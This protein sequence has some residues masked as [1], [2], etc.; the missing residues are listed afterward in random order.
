M[1]CPP[2]HG[3]VSDQPPPRRLVRHD[4]V[5]SGGRALYVYGA[6]RGEPRDPSEGPE[7]GDDRALHRRLDRL[8][9][10]WVAVSPSR[11]VRP[12]S[13][14]DVVCPLCPGGAELAFGYEAAVF[15]NR[16]PSLVA[17]PPP[18]GPDPRRA[19]SVGR[20]EVVLYTEHHEG[21]LA[22]L[23]PEELANVIGIWRDRTA[24]LWADRRH[25]VVMPFENR[26]EAVGAT[27]SHPHGQLYAFDHLPPV[28]AD[29]VEAA[30][31]HAAG[32]DCLGCAVVRDDEDLGRDVLD[33]PP[34]VTLDVIRF[35]RVRPA[36][37]SKYG[38]I[39]TVRNG[40]RWFTVVRS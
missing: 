8:S 33:R 4:L 2:Y 15:E 12:H 24:A 19:P 34:L 1:A 22:T 10:T 29:R 11:N 25:R 3:P 17:S 23:S 38:W 40:E 21:S 37:A 35:V 27:L 36:H 14:V 6:L 9:G 5:T 20:C 28:I 13:R 18:A 26:G 16:F 32:G 31:T 30:R 39:R 7:V